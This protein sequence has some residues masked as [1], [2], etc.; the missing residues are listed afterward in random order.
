MR[1]ALHFGADDAALHGAASETLRAWNDPNRETYTL[2]VSN[3]IF[4]ST[5]R[6]PLPSFMRFT[7]EHYLAAAEALNFSDTEAAR[8]RI[9]GWVEERTEQ[10]IEELFGP[11]AIQPTTQMVLVNAVYFHGSWECPF[12]AAS[13]R[14]A[15]FRQDEGT[16]LQVPTMFSAVRSH[17]TAR[18]RECRALQLPYAGGDLAMLFVLPSRRMSTLAELEAR[19]TQELLERDVGALH[20]SSLVVSLPRF[21]VA[22]ES[23][24]LKPTLQALGMRAAFERSADFSGITG[25]NDLWIDTVVHKAF[26][27]VNEEGTEAAAATGVGLAGRSSPEIFRVDRPFLFFLRDLNTG[28]ILF[29][30]RVVDPRAGAGDP[31]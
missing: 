31:P 17:W 12:R 18:T 10:R 5:S 6:P 3:R 8:A 30:G 19:W 28:A 21:R 20:E 11:D 29:M 2:A 13:T 25:A 27:E 24:E 16:V 22:G 26:I 9:N 4:T 23:L 14:P 1:S 7:G 15:A